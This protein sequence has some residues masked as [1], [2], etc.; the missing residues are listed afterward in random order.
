VVQTVPDVN[1]SAIASGPEGTWAVENN[2]ASGS[3][4][5]LT[6]DRG[7]VR[8]VRIPAVQLATS[9]SSIAVGA[10]APHVR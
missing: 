7:A 5:Q 9:L 1:V 10:G 2:A 6:S 8:H 4:A 3:I